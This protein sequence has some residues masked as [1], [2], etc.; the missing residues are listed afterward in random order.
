MSNIENSTEIK[1]EHLLHSVKQLSPVELDEFTRKLTEWRRQREAVIGEDINPD[2]S[3][4]A[5]LAF[6]RKNSQLPEK[7]HRRYWQLR[8]KSDGETLTD[9]ELSEYQ[10]LV[11]WLTV[12]NAKRLEALA[13]LVQR[14]GRPVEEIMV[15]LGLVVSH[16]EEPQFAEEST[17][18]SYTENHSG[19]RS[20]S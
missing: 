15:E 17:S 1:V 4:A 18:E 11:R 10:K 12:M 2:A 7:E 3:D 20:D 19:Q 8:R 14:W 16:F 5:I 6:I 13:I 9:D